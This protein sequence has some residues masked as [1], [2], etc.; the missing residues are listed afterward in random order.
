MTLY[1]YN[2]LTNVPTKYQLPTPYGLR[3]IAQIMVKLHHFNHM[4]TKYCISFISNLLETKF[5]HHSSNY[6]KVYNY[7]IFLI[8]TVN[9]LTFNVK[10]KVN[11]SS[12][13]QINKF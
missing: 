8:S 4:Y 13:D 3:G 5:S 6:S 10:I 9:P 12:V 11:C 7:M 1:T 2:P